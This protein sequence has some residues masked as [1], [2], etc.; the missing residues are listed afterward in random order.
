MGERQSVFLPRPSDEYHLSNFGVLLL[1]LYRYEG[2]SLQKSIIEDHK[3]DFI[4]DDDYTKFDMASSML[5][6]ISSTVHGINDDIHYVDDCSDPDVCRDT[7]R[8]IFR[9][10]G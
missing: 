4:C 2:K 8:M 3:E 10:M 9:H 1:Q 6:Y 5:S 7:F